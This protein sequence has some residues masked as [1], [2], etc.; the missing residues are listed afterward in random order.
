MKRIHTPIAIFAAIA[1]TA[2]MIGCDAMW[3]TSLDVPLGYGGNLGIGVST[4]IYSSGYWPGNWIGSGWGWNPPTWINPAPVR[5]P[6]RPGGNIA[7][8][9]RPPQNNPGTNWRPPVNNGGSNPPF[10]TTPAP[11]PSVRPPAS[12]AT[13]NVPISPV[14]PGRH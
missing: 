13:P 3:D 14:R 4:P 7:P 9:P 11:L 2:A 1:T 5:P 6:I 12:N 8:A 10:T